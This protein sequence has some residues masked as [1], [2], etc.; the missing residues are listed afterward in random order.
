MLVINNHKKKGLK[1]LIQAVLN[2]I[3]LAEGVDSPL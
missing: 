2:K 1:S 3:S